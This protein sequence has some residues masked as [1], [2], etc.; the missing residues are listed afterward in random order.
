MCTGFANGATKACDRQPSPSPPQLTH[1]AP[2]RRRDP[3]TLLV[4]LGAHNIRTSEPTQQVFS[5]SAVTRHPDYQPTT[6]AND[7]C[8]LKVSFVGRNA[9]CKS[10]LSQLLPRWLS[11]F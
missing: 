8:L 10:G 4:V 9:A 5:I 6:H 11:L 3:R 1:C 2:P 7:I